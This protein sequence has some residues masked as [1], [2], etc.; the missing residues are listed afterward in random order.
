M[1]VFLR[2]LL[3]TNRALIQFSYFLFR[4]IKT[5]SRFITAGAFISAISNIHFL[6]LPQS[7]NRENMVNP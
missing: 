3:M 5:F 2:F 1:Y 4:F 7:L 6:T